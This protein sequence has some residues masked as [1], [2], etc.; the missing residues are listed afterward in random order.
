MTDS[1]KIIPQIK[2]LPGLNN[3]VASSPKLRL[4]E[5]LKAD[6]VSFK[7]NTANK[8]VQKAAKTLKKQKFLESIG[9]LAEEACEYGS[10]PK[11]NIVQNK[12]VRAVE[13][14]Y[15][16]TQSQ[17]RMLHE[18]LHKQGPGGMDRIWQVAEE[19]F[20]IAS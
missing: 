7:G 3:I 13:K 10:R 18:E 8:A 17:V 2:N 5:Q 14:A 12:Q 19:L 4:Q 15:N 20:G 1:I 9:K 16:L 11:S 6:T